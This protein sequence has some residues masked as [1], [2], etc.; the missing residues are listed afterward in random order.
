MEE[1]VYYLVFAVAALDGQDPTVQHV[2]LYI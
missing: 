2:S 1:L